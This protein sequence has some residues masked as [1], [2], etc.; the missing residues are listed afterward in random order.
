MT[1][2]ATRAIGAV[3][4]VAAVTA[5]Y[6]RWLEV[7]NATTA[8]LSFLLMVLVVAATCRLWVA[9]A[10]SLVAMVCFNFF[11]LPP[12]GTLTISD[13]FGAVLVIRFVR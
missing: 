8:A 9:V 4:A 10:T 13:Q 5:A 11:F 7:T 3:A 2:D 6:T 12:V 1:R